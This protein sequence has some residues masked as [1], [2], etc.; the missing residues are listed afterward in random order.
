[1]PQE[2]QKQARTSNQLTLFVRG[3]DKIIAIS[4][5]RPWKRPEVELFA[6][7]AFHTGPDYQQ[8]LPAHSAKR[9]HLPL[10]RSKPRVYR[11]PRE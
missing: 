1:M 6:I 8:L 11:P 3:K 2:T 4:T 5:A 9:A 10:V 7:K